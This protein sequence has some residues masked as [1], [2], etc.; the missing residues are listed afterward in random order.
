MKMEI[1]RNI[2]T[3]DFLA[4][5]GRMMSV[6]TLFSFL[7][8][9]VLRCFEDSFVFNCRYVYV[10]IVNIYLLVDYKSQ[11]ITSQE[12]SINFFDENKHII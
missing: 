3:T 11:E 2:C 5:Y 10:E 9:L 8:Y 7:I 12:I 4:F 1:D 6:W